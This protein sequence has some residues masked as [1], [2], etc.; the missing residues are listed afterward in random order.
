MVKTTKVGDIVTGAT[1]AV[2]VPRVD[3]DDNADID[4]GTDGEVDAEDNAD[5]CR[6]LL[7]TPG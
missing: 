1:I 6:W 5:V 7:A 4:E 3:D 2:W